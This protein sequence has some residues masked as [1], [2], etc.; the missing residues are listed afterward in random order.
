[1]ANNTLPKRSRRGSKHGA[2][3]SSRPSR[4]SGAGGGLALSVIAFVALAFDVYLIACLFTGWTG[5]L[6]RI[7]RDGLTA[8]L[9]GAIIVPLIFLAYAFASIAFKRPIQ[10]FPRQSIGALLLFFSASMLLGMIG[11][12]YTGDPAFTILEPG[13][14]GRSIASTMFANV[15]PLGTSI[16]SL[17]TLCLAL[18]AFGCTGP[19]AKIAAI[20]SSAIESLK[21]RLERRRPDEPIARHAAPDDAEIKEETEKEKKEKEIDAAPI[22]DPDREDDAINDFT[23]EDV[24][25]EPKKNIQT[26]NGIYQYED[27]SDEELRER[28]R[29]LLERAR[30]QT[31]R[32]NGESVDEINGET[33]EQTVVDEVP[34][35]DGIVLP[36]RR[37]RPEPGSIV[38][39]PESIEQMRDEEPTPEKVPEPELAAYEPEPIAPLRIRP[40]RHMAEEISDAATA[41]PQVGDLPTPVEVQ[42]VDEME[43]DE[44]VRTRKG[45]FPPPLDLYGPETDLSSDITMDEARPWGEKIIETL[46]QFGI[47]AEL[48]G[49]LIG[50]T[51]IQ[52][53]I[54][55]QPGV[56]VNK[57]VGLSNDI[58]LALAVESLRVEAPI[59]GMP[60]VGIEIPNPKRRGITLR[61]V[62]EEPAFEETECVLPLPMGV[63]INGEALVVGLEEMPHMLV[64]GTTGSGKSVFVN[65]CIV[66]MCSKRTPE[67]LR[68]ILVDPKMVEMAIYDRLPHLLT[69]PVTD[70]KK[71]V[72][73]L[74]WAVREMESRYELCRSIKVRN[75]ATYN[76]TVLPK[77]R[78]PHIVI[79]V[80]EFADLMMTAAKDVEEY[81][82]RI[83]QKAR[84]VGIHLILATQR[85]SVN[86]IT[87]LIKSNVPVRAA[88]TLPSGVDSRTIIDTIGAEKLLGRG[89]MLYKGTQM[90]NALRVQAPWIDE[91]AILKWLDY[92]VNLFGEPQFIDIEEQGSGAGG[93]GNFQDDDMLDSAVEIAVSSGTASASGLQTRLRVGFARARRLIEMMESAGIIS[94][95]DGAKPRETLVNGDEAADILARLRGE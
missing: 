17:G 66:G 8:W 60:Y 24:R 34:Y 41:D 12:A 6:G 70:P 18:I 75:I 26:L 5:V 4:A 55:P 3:T 89:D 56:K 15:G 46:S 57:I 86:V 47:E 80:D 76:A 16:V 78:L 31:A 50:P 11:L 67:E 32:D 82:C 64:A 7:A 92:L 61:S 22:D 62:L 59:P 93:D 79:V 30:V 33:S 40:A 21:R 35:D 77:D 84:A 20:A 25:D 65:S 13:T 73:A 38:L 63:T 58:A 10:N 39:T 2:N 23:I 53:R 37:P 19:F 45:L 95:A 29:A 94:P 81:V 52:F 88:F 43:Y 27:L 74:G 51:V 90:S 1:M 71:A 14:L 28:S 48:A 85:P 54:Q 72:H 83:A 44:S 36:P 68:M 91:K 69:P 49:A 9:G 87:G 42:Q